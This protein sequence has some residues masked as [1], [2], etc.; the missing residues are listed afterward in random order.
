MEI[1]ICVK[2]VPDDSVEVKFDEASGLPKLDGITP[3]V[4]AFD[5]YALE[6]AARFKEANGGSITVVSVGGEK[7]KDSVRNCLAVGADKGFVVVDES[8]EGSDTFAT[9]YILSKAKEKIEEISG[10]KFDLVFCGQEATDFVSGQVG[11]QLA[12]IL[13]VNQVTNIIA[14]DPADGG[15]LAKQ[16]TEEGYRMV[17]AQVPAVVTVSK[18]DYDPR[19][20]TMRNK[21][22]ARKMEI[23]EFSA[24]DLGTDESKVGASGS[25][26][27][28]VKSFAPE[29]KNAGLKIKEE[30]AE[31]SAIKA[32]G[33][34]AEA[35]VF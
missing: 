17:S 34:M 31:E 27:K 22:A 32:V 18:P 1:L 35:K 14:I 25:F 29:K 19:Y 26:V 12:E 5:G 6:M 8:F 20:P 21:M 7:A 24:A 3:I 28:V 33:M 10:V 9:S 16:E 15:I 30:T 2:Q 23:L 13:G 11:I 4:N